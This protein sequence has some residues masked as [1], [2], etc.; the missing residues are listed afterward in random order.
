M[1]NRFLNALVLGLM[2]VAFVAAPVAA[3]DAMSTNTPAAK[4]AK[5]KK[6]HNTT[7]KGKL[8]KLDDVNKTITVGEQTI[9][10]TSE[11]RIYNDGKPAIMADGL[12][13]GP[14]H[15]TY[16]KS[17]DGKLMAVS[18]QYGTK[19]APSDNPKPKKKKA[20]K[21]TATTASDTTTNAVPPMMPTPPPA[22][23]V[24]PPVEAP[25]TTNSPGT[26]G[27]N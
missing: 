9:E 11:T 13:G 12:I 24:T 22:M 26:G 1:T 8:D 4:P 23:P 10:I 20:K 7:F 19:S 16:K 15:G 14:V 6:A 2:A 3:Q 17:D 5:T 21:A 18:V 27:M 25:A